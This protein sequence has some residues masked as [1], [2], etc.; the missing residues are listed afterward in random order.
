VAGLF[1]LTLLLVTAHT[2]YRMNVPNKPKLH[3]QNGLQDFR[4]AVYYPVRAL[5]DGR[6]PYDPSDFLANYPV[7]SA[8]PLYSPALLTLHLPWNLLPHVGAQLSYYFLH[9]A[10]VPVFAWLALRLAGARGTMT[11][12]LLVSALLLLS[13]PGH[14]N[15]FLGQ[16]TLYAGIGT[17]AVLWGRSRP[18]LAALGLVQNGIRG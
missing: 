7:A 18:L 4:D 8:F 3:S 16:C 14:H 9:L 10:L 11:A 12:V 2:L 15:A 1:V 13:R 5:L 17:Y 6:N